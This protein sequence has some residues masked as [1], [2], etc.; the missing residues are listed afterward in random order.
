MARKPPEPA[1]RE[2]SS[3]AGARRGRPPGKAAGPSFKARRGR[4]PGKPL[5]AEADTPP[6]RA[7]RQAKAPSKRASMRRTA[8]PATAPVKRRASGQRRV[9]SSAEALTGQ[10]QQILDELGELR[11]I[12]TA[13]QA[14]G[15]K[16]D[17]VLRQVGAPGER[18]PGDAV[19]PGVAVQSPAPLSAEDQA[20]LEK[21]ENEA[22]ETEDTK[23]RTSD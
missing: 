20:V 17:A 18:D 13:V 6:S 3:S 11:G 2:T 21:L 5:G 10:M 4:P 23:P 22:P 7:K 14:L 1:S 9:R 8:K 19:P 16:L 15:A 12:K